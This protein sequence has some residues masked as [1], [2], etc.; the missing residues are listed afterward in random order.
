[1]TV[2]AANTI[3]V[4]VEGSGGILCPLRFDEKKIQLEDFIKARGLACLMI[5]D[6]GLGVINAAVLTAEYMEKLVKY[7]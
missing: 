5:A 1:M 7:L 6:A 2:C 4:T 3:M